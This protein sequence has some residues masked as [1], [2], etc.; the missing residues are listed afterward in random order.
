MSPKSKRMHETCLA[1]ALKCFFFSVFFMPGNKSFIDQ[2]GQDGWILA[3][4]SL[5]LY[6]HIYIKTLNTFNT[7]DAVNT[8]IAEHIR[9]L[10]CNTIP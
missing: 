1:F 4:F 10:P 3:S 2:D 6:I 5:Y 9:L 8:F 7:A